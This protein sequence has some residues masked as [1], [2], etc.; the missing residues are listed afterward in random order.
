VFALSNTIQSYVVII[1]VG[2]AINLALGLYLLLWD[3]RSTVN[4]LVALLQNLITIWGI[5]TIVSM[6]IEAKQVTPSAFRALQINALINYLGTSFIGCTWLHISLLF[7]RRNPVTR[8]RWIYPLLYGPNA[9]FYLLR[10]TNSWHNLFYRESLVKGQFVNARGPIFWCFIT[11]TYIQVGLAVLLLLRS[12]ARSERV[13]SKKQAIILAG[14][15]LLVLSGHIVRLVFPDLFPTDP[16]L[17]IFPLSGILYT[18]GVL[19]YRLL[20]ISTILN[21][22]VIYGLT[23]IAL[24][25]TTFVLISLLLPAWRSLPTWKLALITTLYFGVL[26]IIHNWIANLVRRSLDRDRLAHQHAVQ[27]FMEQLTSVTGSDKL[28]PGVVDFIVETM[29]AESGAI[30]VRDQ[31]KGDYTLRYSRGLGNL[32]KVEYSARDPFFAHMRELEQ[33]EVLERVQIM[34]HSRYSEI[35][36]VAEKHMNFWRAE[37]CL[38]LKVQEELIGVMTFGLRTGGRSYRRSDIRLFARVARQVAISVYNVLYYDAIV[39]AQRQLASLNEDLE[40]RVQQRAEELA[41]ANEELRQAQQQIIQSEKLAAIG[42]LAAG[43]AHE[44]NNPV[45]VILGFSQL[46]QR[47][48]PPDDPMLEGLVAIERESLRCKQIVQNLLDFARMGEPRL[49]KVN[50]NQTLDTTCRLL[51]Y[52][53]SKSEVELVKNYAPALPKIMADPQQMQQVFVNIILNAYQSMPQGGRLEI[54]TRAQNN[55]VVVTFSDEGRGIP[56]EHLHR[57][58]EPFF[59]TKTA[60]EGTG[61]GLS[62][63]YGIVERHGGHIEV[64]SELNKGSTF[65]VHLPISLAPP[66]NVT[67]QGG[68]RK[69]RKSGRDLEIRGW[70]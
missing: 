23:W 14:A 22:A 49:L 34:T 44:I 30:I 35:R 2:L 53:L 24:A 65:T 11:L 63:S 64:E 29:Y 32:E 12:T 56:S 46:L 37:V 27:E 25:A 9:L 41:E 13:Q 61:L 68:G 60:G 7:P 3:P 26:N 57:I 69:R 52:Q 51:K 1:S 50:L 36:E 33:D 19:R 31:I 67:V 66:T 20:G 40:R 54:K 47:R 15:S 42:Q 4:R 43:V 55:K 70:E 28:L 18:Y 5:T 38:T 58:F 39:T 59:T 10:L 21:R 48:I 45:G 17:L 16:S 8:R 62:V 6:V